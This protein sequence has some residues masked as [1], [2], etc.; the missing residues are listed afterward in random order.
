MVYSRFNDKRARAHGLIHLF[1]T[2]NMRFAKV[3]DAMRDGYVV[4]E[5]GWA[6]GI[7]KGK[8]P[9]HSTKEAASS[10]QPTT[11]HVLGTREWTYGSKQG[12]DWAGTDGA[13]V[14]GV[15]WSKVW[16]A[17]QQQEEEKRNGGAGAEWWERGRAKEEK[18]GG[19]ACV[20]GRW[21]FVPRKLCNTGVL[22]TH[23]LMRTECSS[24]CVML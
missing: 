3:Q 5:R 6:G 13:Y 24:K 14:G 16:A 18:V 8:V 10:H 23:C 2:K 22:K 21:L 19:C 11:A 20:W 12:S 1:K 4:S 15:F 9:Q 17:I 7:E